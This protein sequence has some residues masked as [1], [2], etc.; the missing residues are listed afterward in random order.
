MNGKRRWIALILALTML[1]LTGCGDQKRREEAAALVEE[2]KFI[3]AYNIYSGLQDREM[4]DDTREK[5][6]AAAQEAYNSGNFDRAAEILESFTQ[7]KEFKTFLEDVKVAQSGKSVTGLKLDGSTLSFTVSRG[8]PEKDVV[9][10]KLEANNKA[11]GG[12][13]YEVLKPEDLPAENPC[14]VTIDLNETKWTA[15]VNRV[16]SFFDNSIFDMASQ[17]MFS[18]GTL[19][20]FYKCIRADGTEGL[21]MGIVLISFGFKDTVKT[22]EGGK[23]AVA[24]Y[25][26]EESKNS[27][28]NIPGEQSVE[29]PGAEEDQPEQQAEQQSET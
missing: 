26:E 17:S 6:F 16:F 14:T 29:I 22:F 7:Y 23:V 13:I 4:K 25:N 2:G 18:M 12:W 15:S 28:K 27:D 8:D 10:I 19:S 1:L 21:T 11:V 5:A 9:R 3:E 24:V 20:T